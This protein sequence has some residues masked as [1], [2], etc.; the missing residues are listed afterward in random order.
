[1]DTIFFCFAV[2]THHGDA[3]QERFAG[4]YD[5]MK[6]TIAPGTLPQDAVV[7]VPPCSQS[8]QVMVPEGAGEGFVLRV[9]APQ[10]HSIEVIV[11]AGFAAGSVMTLTVP[12]D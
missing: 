6:A 11:P 5:T 8:I 3:K 2:E 1:M 10:G 7:G 9:P 4:L 12:N